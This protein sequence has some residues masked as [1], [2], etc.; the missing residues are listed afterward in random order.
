[1]GA[2]IS[3]LTGSNDKSEVAVMAKQATE[4]KLFRTKTDMQKDYFCPGTEGQKNVLI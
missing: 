3:A 2:V 4:V 1:M